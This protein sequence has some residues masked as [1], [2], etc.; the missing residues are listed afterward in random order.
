MSQRERLEVV[1]FSL[2][3]FLWTFA[4][5]WPTSH[6]SRYRVLCESSARG[7]NREFDLE[8]MDSRN[9]VS[10]RRIRKCRKAYLLLNDRFWRE[11][12]I[13]NIGCVL[14]GGYEIAMISSS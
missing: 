10:S 7:L 1:M 12:N 6:T 8:R 11:T 5:K 9:R 3:A 4:K 2:G 13:P 14:S